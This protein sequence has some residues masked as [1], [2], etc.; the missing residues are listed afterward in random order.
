MLQIPVWLHIFNYQFILT[1]LLAL[2]YLERGKWAMS[3]QTIWQKQSI[4]RKHDVEIDLTK[5][6]LQVGQK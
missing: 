4:K 5:K 3:P 6:E 1:S 2:A